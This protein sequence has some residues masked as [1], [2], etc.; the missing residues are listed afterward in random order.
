V[1][2]NPLNQADSE[3]IH[4]N[5][6]ACRRGSINITVFIMNVR[7]GSKQPSFQT[8]ADIVETLQAE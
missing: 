5:M 6:L 8:L 4:D 7:P 2:S 3:T 1:A